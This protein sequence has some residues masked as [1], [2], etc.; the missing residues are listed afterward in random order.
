MELFD[1]S[2]DLLYG[3][4]VAGDKKR[5]PKD[6]SLGDVVSAV[7]A[8][9]VPGY[10]PLI[11]DRPMSPRELAD[12]LRVSPATIHRKVQRGTLPYFRIGRQIR[13]LP[14]EVLQA[15]RDADDE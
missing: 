15:L 4:C 8:P 11:P 2:R 3:V 14:G 12:F 5:Q 1:R 7:P 13:F 6:A 10:R 9:T